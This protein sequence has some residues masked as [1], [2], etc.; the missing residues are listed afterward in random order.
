MYEIVNE[1]IDAAGY[2]QTA[3]VR[4][5]DV[6]MNFIAKSLSLSSFSFSFSLSIYSIFS[7][8]LYAYLPSE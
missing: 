3:L 4:R 2:L 7:V 1:S 6:K 5:D 8:S